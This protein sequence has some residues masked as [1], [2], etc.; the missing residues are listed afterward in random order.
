MDLEEPD[1]ITHQTSK[2]CF[3]A[4][5]SPKEMIIKTNLLIDDPRT[6]SKKQFQNNI[7]AEYFSK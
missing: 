4:S 6:K 3:K 7:N 1:P 2:Y 5:Y